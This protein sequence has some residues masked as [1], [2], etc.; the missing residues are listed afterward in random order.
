MPISL[1]TVTNATAINWATL[2]GLTL[3]IETYVNEGIATGDLS[4]TPWVRS[5]QVF[6]P[7]FN[8]GV[9]PSVRL[10]SG[11]IHWRYRSNADRSRS[12]HHSQINTPG[13][14]PG[15]AGSYVP[16]EGM[17]ISYSAPEVISSGASCDHRVIVHAC[18]FVHE[19]GGKGTPDEATNHVA[20]FGLFVG[21][22]VKTATVRDVY[23]ASNATT[24]TGEVT[25]IACKQYS[26]LYPA[27]V[28]TADLHDLGV[29]VRMYGM[30]P[31]A[32]GQDDWRH[33]FVWGRSTVAHWR[34]R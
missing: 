31:G 29:R 5:I 16:V 7:Q 6:K 2:R 15:T 12:I 19:V 28:T 1:T 11:E 13:A 20:D 32:A 14:T 10:S 30:T 17:Q 25:T 33:L 34:I 8:A 3:D 4:T 22:T 9:A 18:W 26:I 27:S 23:T 24:A 21:G